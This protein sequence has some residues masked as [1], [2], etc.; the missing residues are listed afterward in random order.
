MWRNSSGTL[1]EASGFHIR[2]SGDGNGCVLEK[3]GITPA[4]QHDLVL[5][6]RGSSCFRNNHDLPLAVNVTAAGVPSPFGQAGGMID[7][8]EIDSLALPSTEYGDF[9]HLS[10]N[11]YVHVDRNGNLYTFTIDS[12]G[13]ISTIIDSDD[14]WSEAVNS[15]T[16]MVKV[17]DTM[18]AIS[19]YG[20][21][22][23]NLW[24]SFITTV[25]IEQDGTITGILDSDNFHTGYGSHAPSIFPHAQSNLFI[26]SWRADDA[27]GGAP[28]YRG[29]LT[30]DIDSNGV[31]TEIDR[32]TGYPD[33]YVQSSGIVHVAGDYYAFANGG[34][35][36]TV[37][38]DSSGIITNPVVDQYQLY[39]SNG[40]SDIIS[41]SNNIIAG[42]SCI[43]LA[44]PTL[45]CIP[46]L[47]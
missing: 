40:P 8:P 21:I 1:V 42:L 31:I 17:S 20:K 19:Y 37:A 22:G 36:K 13:N 11:L 44:R 16:R 33:N 27:N 23:V 2:T 14:I 15:L 7:E 28:P 43:A 45:F 12:Q 46:P 9:I 25:R 10:G 39:S 4:G 26:V 18:I 32:K 35:L 47:N 6:T 30:V 34:N 41:L 3:D 5:K 29:I 24:S 38:I